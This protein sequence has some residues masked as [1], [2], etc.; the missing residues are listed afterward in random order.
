[1]TL[2]RSGLGF[3]MLMTISAFWFSDA[4][5]AVWV[6]TFSQV[7]QCRWSLPVGQF[8]GYS[9][10]ERAESVRG[11][12]GITIHI[13]GEITQDDASNFSKLVHWSDELYKHGKGGS[14]YVYLGSKGGSV[15]AAINIA[16]AIRTSASMRGAGSTTVKVDGCY[17][18]CVIVLAGSYR[19]SV[20]GP[21]GIHRP[22]FVGDEAEQM[23][24]K[25]LKQ[26][27]DGLY[28]ELTTLFKQWNLSKSLVDDMFAVASTDVHVLNE[29]ELDSY[30]LSKDD[31]VLTEQNNAEV[32]ATCGEEDLQAIAANPVFWSSARGEECLRKINARNSAIRTAKVKKLCSA[33]DANRYSNGQ[34]PSQGCLDKVDATE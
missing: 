34:R 4:N 25:N 21:V 18:A 28:L 1:M 16:R 32:R 6:S 29:H 30:G 23:G 7:D 27:Y 22:F 12:G 8:L 33:D 15:F 9:N 26:A 24:Y 11:C 13:E 17:S 5:S 10:T 2:N 19:R 14:P 20:F 31:W 3:L